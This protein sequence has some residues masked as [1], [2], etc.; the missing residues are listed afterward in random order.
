MDADSDTH[1]E[2]SQ[3]RS[4]GFRLFAVLIAAIVI[5]E[6]AI[7]LT[8]GAF[9]LQIYPVSEVVGALVL[10]GF[11]FP[12]LYYAVFKDVV[13]KNRMLATTE[14]RLRAAHNW[15]EQCI[16]E[17]TQEIQTAN[18]KLEN[19]VLSLK[20]QRREMAVLAEMGH[21]LQACSVVDEACGI[22]ED[23]L[24]RL[25]PDMSGALYLK[26]GSS[27]RSLVRITAWGKGV[28]LEDQF[29]LDDCWALRNARP[30]QVDGG[31]PATTCAHRS[32]AKTDWH[33]CLP[34]TAQGETL[35]LICLQ[36][37]HD[38]LEEIGDDGRVSEDR[39][40]FYVMIADSLALAIANLR[41]RETLRHQAIRDPLTGLYNRR[42]FDDALDREL[43]RA[44]RSRQPLSLVMLDIDDFKR[45]N[46]TY[47]HGGGDAL[48][49]GLATLLRQRLREED[50][51]C[52][53][54]GDEFALVLPGTSAEEAARRVDGL[55]KEIM[56][57]AINH[58]AHGAGRASIS[59]GIAEYPR[60]TRDKAALINA[61]DTALYN[62]KAASRA[63][64]A[65]GET[66]D[67]KPA[68][69]NVA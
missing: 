52:R 31:N 55:R 64:P 20:H 26:D 35:G 54:G 7:N 15:L 67:H 25:F 53:F 48:L 2:T 43:S 10:T 8:L 18:R 29:G 65:P 57:S 28:A 39:L 46:D 32:Y 23:H 33:L 11:L 24:H 50:T 44:E 45:F 60:D 5:G 63:E 14:G 27:R 59:T 62:A 40:R 22:V 47:G 30:H 41:L 17:R 21:L 9:D 12:V 4:G 42:H 3:Y 19:A 13:Q 68:R 16:D 49:E 61:A 1:S 38:T 66:G 58:P 69:S 51:I 6:R 34:M 37:P 56:A 36:A